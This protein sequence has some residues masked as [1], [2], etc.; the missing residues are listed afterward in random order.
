MMHNKL[1]ACASLSIL[2]LPSNKDNKEKSILIAFAVSDSLALL[3]FKQLPQRRL[4]NYKNRNGDYL[5]SNCRDYA[6][7]WKLIYRFRLEN[8]LI[9]FRS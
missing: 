6:N 3:Q 5:D 1:A 2:K 4:A 7:L 9:S 8:I